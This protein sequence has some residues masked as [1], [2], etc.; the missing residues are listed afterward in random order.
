MQ[1]IGVV[2]LYRFAEG[3]RPVL[4]FLETYHRYSAGIEHD[5]YV[6]FKGFPD[7]ATL[8][9]GRAVFANTPFTSIELDD[10]GYDVGSYLNAAKVVSNPKLFFLN[11]FSQILARDW[12]KYFDRAINL[13]GVGL[14]GA[15]GSWLA[16]TAGYEAMVAAILRGDWNWEKDGDWILKKVRSWPKKLFQVITPD[17][18]RADINSSRQQH[19]RAI[20]V[21]LLSPFDYLFKFYDCGRYPN[22]HIR[23][24]AFMIERSRLLS[25]K[26]SSFVTKR[27]VY[28]F[29]HGR[30]SLTKQILAQGLKPVV[31]DRS[32]NVYDI[33]QWKLSS[34]FWTDEQENLIISD[35]R[36]LDYTQGDSRLRKKLENFAWVDP[37]LWHDN[38][39]QPSDPV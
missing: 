3:E 29:E 15:T 35:N 27:S 36:T 17:P 26:I 5:L 1:E 6:V 32:G 28:R 12:L 33:S 7:I 37:W 9:L 25:L 14:V 10:S 39:D 38:V 16:P 8:A 11:T 19:K 23:T 18:N 4:R 22:P 24:N 34:T 20:R 31:V 21:L 30:R 13:R 2:Y